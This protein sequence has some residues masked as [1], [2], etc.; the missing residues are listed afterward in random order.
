MDLF[1][2]I[3]I[4]IYAAFIL[5]C[6]LAVFMKRLDRSSESNRLYISLGFLLL[7]VLLL[8]AISIAME[9]NPTLIGIN[10]LL[11][12]IIFSISPFT[13]LLWLRFVMSRISTMVPVARIC[14]I[15]LVIPAV[16]GMLLSISN[17]WA[18]VYFY[19]NAA[20]QYQR[21]NLIFLSAV[22]TYFYVFATM[23]IV[24]RYRKSLPASTAV[25][26]MLFSLMPI[27][28]SILQ[29]AYYGT[30]LM[31]SVSALG[32]VILS[33]SLQ[34]Q[35]MQNDALTGAWTRATFDN[36]VDHR[37]HKGVNVTMGVIFMDLDGL[38]DIN[39]QYGHLEG[40]HALKTVAR[41]ARET[42][43]PEDIFVRFGGD[44]F[45]ALLPGADFEKLRETV[46]GM[47]K[48]ANEY[49]RMVYKPYQVS[50]SVGYEVFSSKRD[51]I[52]HFLA[53]VDSLMYM[54]KERKKYERKYAQSE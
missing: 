18:P 23:I 21:G 8:E 30:S 27:L 7:A 6:I 45:V 53:H 32:M 41:I 48:A 51:K 38:K 1:L 39:D 15:C 43:G 28:G 2:K 10:T 22:I 26:L 24:L 46:E 13:S 49:N 36:Y 11:N 44:E 25:A 16:I 33:L 40:D 31:F 34:Q 42:L 54:N 19:F 4:N 3:D 20:G 35:M 52:G 17:A 14:R 9:G 5:V 12:I 47:E 50:F 37:L 29:F